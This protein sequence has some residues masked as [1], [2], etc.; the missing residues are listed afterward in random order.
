MP[1]LPATRIAIAVVQR[2][3]EVLIGQR[4]EGVA[5][6]GLWEFPGGKIEPG[7]TPAV[8]AARECREEAGLD[9]VVG[10]TID[11]IHH[12]Y[13]H[14]TVELH[15][16]ACHVNEAGEPSGSFRWVHRQELSAYEFPA[17]NTP[18]LEKLASH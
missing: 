15:F 4:P 13:E 12:T 16:I 5:L 10:E 11:V 17:A 8:A 3:D 6:A 1:E 14:D 9:V 7:E 18:I 2:G